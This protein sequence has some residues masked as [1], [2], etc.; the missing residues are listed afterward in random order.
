MG[1]A[2]PELL[3]EVRF[4]EASA[5]QPP[6]PGDMGG[7]ERVEAPFEQWPQTLL[8]G[9]QGIEALG[10]LGNPR[11]DARQERGQPLAVRGSEVEKMRSWWRRHAWS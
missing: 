1:V 6:K 3:G 9:K 4:V 8:L 5:E 2:D 10:D 7:L 11:L